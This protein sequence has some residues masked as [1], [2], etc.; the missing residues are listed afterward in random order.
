MGAGLAARGTGAGLGTGAGRAEQAGPADPAGRAGPDRRRGRHTRRRPRG[1]GGL[2]HRRRPLT[3]NRTTV[4][5][6]TGRDP[7]LR[8]H[9]EGYGDL[10]HHPLARVLGQGRLFRE[11]A[12]ND[13]L[14]DAGVHALS[15]VSPQLAG[16]IGI[17]RRD[18]E[19]RLARSVRQEVPEDV[20]HDPGARQH[21]GAELGIGNDRTQRTPNLTM[22][23]PRRIRHS[24]TP[25]G[26]A[27]QSRASQS[28]RTPKLH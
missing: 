10:V 23:I 13:S 3:D 2:V 21:L 15:Q 17:A 28:T 25:S 20:R 27:S 19:V 4:G 26:W 18:Q 9:A 8:R 1:G 7:H 22:W 14:R 6:R 11:D 5:F 24:A 12:G 16:H